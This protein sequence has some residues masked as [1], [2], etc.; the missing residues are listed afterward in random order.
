MTPKC[1]YCNSKLDA[2]YSMAEEKYGSP[3]ENDLTVCY[4]CG[5]ISIFGKAGK[6]LRKMNDVDKSKI[7][8]ESMQMAMSASRLIKFRKIQ[9]N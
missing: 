4:Y 5:E 1:P 3:S 6:S 8:D 2:N 7:D 9:A